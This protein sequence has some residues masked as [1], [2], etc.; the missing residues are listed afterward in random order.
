MRKKF[1]TLLTLLLTVCSGAWAATED[2]AVATS[3]KTAYSGTSFTTSANMMTTSTSS[4]YIKVR[5]NQDTPNW[6]FTVKDGYKITG[7]KIVGY[8]NNS[9]ETATITMTSMNI[10]GGENILTGS[11][12]TEFPTGKDNAITL[13]KS[14]FNAS[15]SITCNFD[16]TNITGETGAKNA[17]LMV[18]ITITYEATGTPV[19]LSFSSA[20][21][22]VNIGEDFTEPIL[23]VT[24][25]AAESEIVYSSSNTSVATVNAETGAVSILS[26]GSTTITAAIPGSATYISTSA[27]YTLSVIDPTAKSVKYSPAYSETAEITAGTTENITNGEEVVATFTYS[28]AGEN[29]SFI[30]NKE[31]AGRIFNGITFNAMTEGNG[32]NGNIAGGTFYTIV[33]KYDG[34]IQMAVVINK[35]KIIIVE[36]D[37]VAMAGF[38]KKTEK[39][40][41]IESFAVK[42][43]KSYKC[44]VSGSKMGLYGFV[45]SYFTMEVSTL[46]GR[47]YATCVPIK[48]LDFGSADGITAYIAKGLNGSKTAVMLQE[49]NKVEAGTPVI[50]KTD[51]KGATV[52]VPVTTADAD[53]TEGNLLVAGDGTTAW[54]GTTGYVYYYLASDQMHKATSGTLQSGKAYLKIAEGSA[55]APAFGFAFGEETTGIDAVSSTRN[56]SDRAVYNMQ[57]QRIGQPRKGLYIIGGKKVVVK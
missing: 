39:F 6:T 54:D 1:F 29:N 38:E 10:D 11:D 49:V 23:T 37:G 21:A 44:Y 32:I 36:E 56:V 5:A 12:A 57:G 7:I 16:C 28:E 33:P 42:A 48:R 45:Y 50:V 19:T 17:Q 30:F 47:N 27:S 20:T 25:A 13:N 43:G 9:V 4:G 34:S 53:D 14:G 46:S 26:S 41:G 31:S 15:S 52:N 40:Y 55:T 18:K 22:N 24:P 2:L 3:D 8:S 35:D 51:T